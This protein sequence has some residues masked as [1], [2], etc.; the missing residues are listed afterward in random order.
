MQFY[1]LELIYK[2]ATVITFN[3]I[4][5]YDYWEN[6]YCIIHRENRYP[7]CFVTWSNYKISNSASTLKEH[8]TST[9]FNFSKS[10]H[11][12]IEVTWAF[13][14][15]V[16]ISFNN[17]GSSYAMLHAWTW[18]CVNLKQE[19]GIMGVLSYWRFW[20]YRLDERQ[21]LQFENIS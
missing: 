14:F 9:F 10:F 1:H 17:F 20:I 18:I 15:P 3:K 2:I 7:I 5:K 11:V 19:V 13:L 6:S 4:R 8:S 16:F 21:N 12:W